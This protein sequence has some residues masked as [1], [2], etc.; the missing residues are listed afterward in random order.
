M[1]LFTKLL[2]RRKDSSLDE[3]AARIPDEATAWKLIWLRF[4][5]HRMAMISAF[6]LGIYTLIVTFAPFIAPYSE[7]TRDRNYIK[8][9]PEYVSLWEGGPALPHAQVVTTERGGIEDGFA[10]RQ[11]KY[12][13]QKK[14]SWFVRGEEYSF[15]GIFTSDL[16]LFGV[17]EITLPSEGPIQDDQGASNETTPENAVDT[18]LENQETQSESAI[19]SEAAEAEEAQAS[20]DPFANLERN[21]D[22]GFSIGG[23]GS[24]Q[25]EVDDEPGEQTS[26]EKSEISES[27]GADA[28]ENEDPFAAFE[29]DSDGTFTIGGAHS[30][31][32]ADA[33]ARSEDDSSSASDSS[34]SAVQDSAEVSESETDSLEDEE[35]VEAETIDGFIH[36]LGTDDLGRDQFSRLMYATRTSLTIGLVGLMVAFVLGL[37]F[38]GIAGYFGGWIDYG[39][40]RLIEVVR[41]IPT[42][43]L[44]MGLAAALPQEWSN[45]RVFF[46]T[47]IILGLVG[48]TTLAR[49]VR[50]MLMSLQDEDFVIAARL[51]GAGPFRIITRHM[52]PS[53]FSYIVVTLTIEFPY[54]ILAESVLSFVGLG[55]RPP[56]VSWGVLLQEAQKVEVLEQTPWLL[57]PALFVMIVIL[58]FNF[59]G[60]GLRDAA[61]P[62]QES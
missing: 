36:L 39:I 28:G 43:P 9:P 29:R 37:I 49:R 8:G 51:S 42:I 13:A 10:Y 33:G 55:L 62:Y 32:D 3:A 25:S 34:D 52:L 15:L 4:R 47:S 27:D 12:D 1:G 22:G 6:V 40:Q 56:S 53:F 45:V 30:D 50:G 18:G 26:A 57:F 24:D 48:W 21:E 19:S 31:G 61:D 35:L 5:R 41:S 58:A 23:A 14:I 16:H 11:Q 44:V 2:G 54:M 20:N 17:K 46:F 38:G 60:D 7:T 59:V